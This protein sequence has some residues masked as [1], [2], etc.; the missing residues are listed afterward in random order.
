MRDLPRPGI[1]LVSSAL[2]GRFLFTGP[3]GKLFKVFKVK[4]KFMEDRRMCMAENLHKYLVIMY[5]WTVC[6]SH[7]YAISIFPS[8]SH[9]LIN[10]Q[11]IGKTPGTGLPAAFQRSGDL[12]SHCVF[13]KNGLSSHVIQPRCL[14]PSLVGLTPSVVFLP[15]RGLRLVWTWASS[16]EKSIAQGG[17][18]VGISQE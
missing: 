5:F 13:Q 16:Q 10:T 3:P 12:L 9:R 2:A 14:A 15:K 1:E 18:G 11:E 4:T 7:N 8:E 6:N 17:L